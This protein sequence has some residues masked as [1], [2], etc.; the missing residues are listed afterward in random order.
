MP[1]KECTA[2][3]GKSKGPLLAVSGRWTVK[4]LSGWYW[5]KA[6]VSASPLYLYFAGSMS[7]YRK[8][9]RLVRI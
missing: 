2:Q 9:W 8:H 3:L 7:G 1:W 4:L 6:D 5:P